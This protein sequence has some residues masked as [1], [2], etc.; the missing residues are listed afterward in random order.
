[1]ASSSVCCGSLHVSAAWQASC[2]HPQPPSV[3]L[4]APGEHSSPLCQCFSPALSLPFSSREGKARFNCCSL[5]EAQTRI[6]VWI[7]NGQA[8]L[9]ALKAHY[10]IRTYRYLC[11]KALPGKAQTHT[12]LAPWWLQFSSDRTPPKFCLCKLVPKQIRITRSF[13][14]LLLMLSNVDLWKQSEGTYI[15]SHWG[16]LRD[17][18]GCP[19]AA[20]TT[21]LSLPA[22]GLKGG[23]G[24]AA[25]HLH[26]HHPL[27]VWKLLSPSV[28]PECN[29]Q[30]HFELPHNKGHPLHQ[31][32][33]D[34]L[35]AL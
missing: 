19:A 6:Q 14:P 16:R 1:M 7:T 10:N 11:S 35:S 15:T 3:C 13:L 20:P 12:T 27:S 24:G 32:S 28:L 22:E 25:S 21:K 26:L 34:E 31:L 29:S 33:Y 9:L 18:L 4:P 8:P 30:H 17:G 2:S 23:Q 5:S